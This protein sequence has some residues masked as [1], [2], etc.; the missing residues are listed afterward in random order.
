M[1]SW[2][3]K[4]QSNVALSTAEVEYIV[5]CFASCESIWLHNLMSGLFDMDLDTI[6]IL[7][8]N[9]IC[10]KMAKNPVFHDKSKNIEI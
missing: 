10:I 1:I 6:V 5:A 8:D 2:F 3:S 9:Q 7:Y 4:K